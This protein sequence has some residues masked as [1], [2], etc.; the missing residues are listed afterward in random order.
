MIINYYTIHERHY[1][2][3]FS[4]QRNKACNPLTIPKNPIHVYI[5]TS[6]AKHKPCPLSSPAY[7]MTQRTTHSQY[8]A[9]Q[10][11]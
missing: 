2:F 6:S 9:L 4:L 11:M 10:K 1:M 3:L 5:S 8:S 7:K